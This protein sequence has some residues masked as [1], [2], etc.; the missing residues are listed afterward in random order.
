MAGGVRRK[1]CI[2]ETEEVESREWLREE[3]R[4]APGFGRE[5]GGT[6]WR[7]KKMNTPWVCCP[8]A[9]AGG[10]VLRIPGPPYLEPRR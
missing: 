5:L 2:K 6:G 9:G 7:G 4:M 8:C 1:V 10:G 3:T